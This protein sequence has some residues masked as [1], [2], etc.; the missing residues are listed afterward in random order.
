MERKSCGAGALA[1]GPVPLAGLLGGRTRASAAVQG[2][3][4]TSAPNKSVKWIPSHRLI[5]CVSRS[6][7]TSRQRNIYD[8]ITH[9]KFRGE[10]NGAQKAPFLRG[11]G[12]DGG[13]K[14]R[15][16][17]LSNR[18][19]APGESARHRWRPVRMEVCRVHRWRV[20]HLEASARSLVRSGD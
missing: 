13:S 11:A 2:D 7:N 17:S 6:V 8:E 1:R 4:P 16:V 9:E 18:S 14:G 19:S 12:V 5:K 3:R 20:G 10:I 15:S